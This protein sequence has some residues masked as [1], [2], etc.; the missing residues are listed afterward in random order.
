MVI[1]SM[2]SI[3]FNGY[4]CEWTGRGIWRAT[5]CLGK[6]AEAATQHMSIHDLFLV[7]RLYVGS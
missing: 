1:I 3:P 7:L 5:R 6:S 4:V 2:L